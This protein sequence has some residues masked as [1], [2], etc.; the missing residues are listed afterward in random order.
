MDS[1]PELLRQDYHDCGDEKY[2]E[3]MELV[4]DR[5]AAHVKMLC[6]AFGSAGLAGAVDRSMTLEKMVEKYKE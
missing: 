6:E 3:V 5:V 4:K 2:A 1:R